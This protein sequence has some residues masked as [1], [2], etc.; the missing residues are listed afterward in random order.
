MTEIFEK[1]S[2]VFGKYKIELLR[3]DIVMMAG[4]D[5][6]HNVIVESVADQI[7]RDRWHRMQ[8][9]DLAIPGEDSEPQPDLLVIERGAFEGPGR[10][11]PAPAATLVLEVVSRYSAHTDHVLKRS[12]YAAGQVPAY[13]IIDPFA[14]Q[15]V[16]LTERTGSG[17][18]ADY[19]NKR[20]T[21]FGDPV[22]LAMLGIALDTSEFQTLPGTAR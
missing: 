12:L 6:V 8:T 3:G 10:L 14:A 7:P 17:E 20:T 4:P 11:I 13:L 22:P 19:L 1:Y 16:L 2:E 9:Q 18:E 15:C 5:R 21:K